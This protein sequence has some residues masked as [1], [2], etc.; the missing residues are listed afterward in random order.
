[1]QS[2]RVGRLDEAELRI[3][4]VNLIGFSVADLSRPYRKQ[5][6]KRRSAEMQLSTRNLPYLLSVS[7]RF[8][9]AR[10]EILTAEENLAGKFLPG[11]SP[12]P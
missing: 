12:V 5:S 8:P 7:E 11:R 10:N 4:E 6:S 1:M 2:I 3:Y 9:H